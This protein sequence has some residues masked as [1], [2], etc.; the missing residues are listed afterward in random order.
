VPIVALAAPALADKTAHVT[1]SV[2]IRTGPSPSRSP[3]GVISAG[4][5]I[6]IYCQTQ[7]TDSVPT[8]V[9]G[10]GTSWLWD[11][12][13]ANV[14]GTYTQ[15]YITDL[16]PDDTPYQVRDP[17]LSDCAN[18]GGIDLNLYCPH[19]AGNTHVGLDSS[20]GAYGWE[21]VS[22]LGLVIPLDD[23]QMTRAC[24]WEYGATDNTPGYLTYQAFY[25]NR[26]D[27]YS[28]RCRVLGVGQ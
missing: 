25:N 2:Y 11:L 27:P 10:H 28:W 5:P 13:S 20:K 24:A 16:A 4:A 21:C 8:A 15:G 1:F 18:L 7:T 9:A 12:V 6:V 17:S 19:M 3:L 26:A 22:P 14:N 23:V